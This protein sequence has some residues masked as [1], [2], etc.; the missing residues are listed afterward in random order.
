[1]FIME[2]YTEE[3]WTPEL[4]GVFEDLQL[5]IRYVTKDE[6]AQMVVDVANQVKGADGKPEFEV[7]LAKSLLKGT[8]QTLRCVVDWKNT[9][10]KFTAI[11]RDKML[12]I[13]FVDK[14][15]IILEGQ[16]KEATLEQYIVWFSTNRDNFL[17]ASAST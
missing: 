15:A 8:K 5:K 4:G 10:T 1:M 2:K 11:N 16:E 7:D 6:Q 12:P 3:A 9:P 17:A 13:L 14:T